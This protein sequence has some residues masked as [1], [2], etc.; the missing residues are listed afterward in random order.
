[1]E[2]IEMSNDSNNDKLL[3]NEESSLILNN[4]KNELQLINT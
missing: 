3:S 2:D 1:M 4:I